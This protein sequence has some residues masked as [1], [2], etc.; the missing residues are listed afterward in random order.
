MNYKEITFIINP[1]NPYRDIL[2]AFLSQ[3]SSFESFLE[4]DKGLK[5]YVSVNTFKVDEIIK[6]CEKINAKISFKVKNIDAKNWNS[7]WEES[8]KPVK[9][10]EDCIIRAP[11][12]K[13]YKLKYEII[14]NPEMTFGT[15]HHETTYG[16]MKELFNHEI[17]KKSVLDFGC[18]TGILSILSEKLGAEM[19]YSID[20]CSNA[21]INA[22]SNLFENKCYKSKVI[23][24]GAEKI[25]GKFDYILANIN[26]NVIIKN[27]EVF[28]KSLL[29]NGIL[30]IS[31]FYQNDLNDILVKAKSFKLEYINHEQ[32]NKWVIS[33]FKKIK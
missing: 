20:I 16:I 4:F 7:N 17:N 30:I 21:C 33:K 28:S 26:K 19:I 22:K 18:G 27:I 23:N 11:F 12:H 13:N 29:L 5:A 6:L 32:N 31:G 3:I 15:G 25:S 24:G 2:L 10:N 8:F 9:I 1:L 14:I